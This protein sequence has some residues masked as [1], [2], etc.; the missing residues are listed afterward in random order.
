MITIV[1]IAVLTSSL[2]FSVEEAVLEKTKLCILN[3]SSIHLS[4][5]QATTAI[6]L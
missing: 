4:L 2:P 5:Q 6:A 1:L 3:F